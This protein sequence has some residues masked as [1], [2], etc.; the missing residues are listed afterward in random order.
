MDFYWSSEDDVGVDPTI[1]VI[2]TGSTTYQVFQFT[3]HSHCDVFVCLSRVGQNII[4]CA[5]YQC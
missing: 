4:I 3:V 2:Q 5:A 1:I